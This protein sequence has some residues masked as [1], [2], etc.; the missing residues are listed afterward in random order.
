MQPNESIIYE[1][2]WNAAI[3]VRISEEERNKVLSNSIENQKSILSD[4]ANKKNIK[5]YKV[6][7]DDGYSGGNFK[8]PG[9]KAM[10]ADIDEGTIDCILIKDLSRFG[11]EHIEGDFYLEMYFPKK[12]VR[13]ISLLEG[14]DSYKDPKRMNSIEI[15]LIN[16]FNEQYLRQVSNA[17]KAS[18]KLKRKEGQFVGSIVPYGYLR[19]P[20]DKYR[21]IVDTEVK[22]IVKKIFSDYISMNNMLYIADNLNSMNVL[23][24]SNRRRQL[25]KKPIKLSSEWTSHTIKTILVQQIYTGDMVQGKTYSYNHKTKKRMP[26]PREKWD[27]VENTHE[28]IISKEDFNKVQM[29]LD[30]KVKPKNS[31]VNIKASVFSGYLICSDCGEKMVRST[32][33]SNGKEYHKFICSTYKKYGTNACSCHLIQ[34]DVLTEIVK[35][36]LNKVVFSIIDFEKKIDKI[37]ENEKKKEIFHLEKQKQKHEDKVEEIVFLKSGL[38]SDYKSGLLTLSEYHSMKDSF[39]EKLITQNK[40]ISAIENQIQDVMNNNNKSKYYE[41]V[42]PY[43]NGIK[44]LSR[45]MIIDF[46]DEIIIDNEKNIKIKFRFEDEL[47]KYMSI[48]DKK[49]I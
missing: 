30:K 49:H 44:R 3:Y 23:S 37:S 17:T 21:L 8:R 13:F 48:F 47:K 4:Y 26:L 40:K 34:E 18:L 29:L 35:E 15:P 12:G 43:V 11:R 24:P 22:H 6:Y 7:E 2:E 16:I 45:K 31:R 9:F 19:N 1:K 5:V 27:I 28:A 14:L 42:K 38:Y 10:L 39:E 46:I 20:E 25:N 41:I 32:S 33:K 36:A